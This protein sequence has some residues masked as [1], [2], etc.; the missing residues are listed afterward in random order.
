MR[1]VTD[2]E[3]EQALWNAVH[4]KGSDY[5]YSRP[6]DLVTDEWT[7]RNDTVCLYAHGDKPGCIVGNVLHQFGIPLEKMHRRE[8]ANARSLLIQLQGAGDLKLSARASAMLSTAQLA[9]D[10]G[11][12]WGLA[13]EKALTA[14]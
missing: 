9:Q 11:A 13:V 2:T 1:A 7:P 8:G 10:S 12:T 4:E 6:D 5:R 14:R 3:V